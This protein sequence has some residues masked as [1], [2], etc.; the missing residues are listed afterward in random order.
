MD[1][2]RSVSPEQVLLFV[3]LAYIGIFGLLSRTR[4]ESLSLQFAIEGLVITGL[5]VVATRLGY[6]VNPIL[7]FFIL[8]TVTMRARWLA[9]LGN[10]LVAR[11]RYRDGLIAFNVALSLWPDAL[12]RR[13]VEINKAV[14]FLRLGYLERA[15]AMLEKVLQSAERD[16]LSPKHVAAVHYNLGIIARAEGDE[17]RARAHFEE[18]VNVAPY[19]IYGYGARQALAGKPLATRTVSDEADAEGGKPPEELL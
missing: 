17:S 5:A 11:R 2:W 4:H 18:A 16:G 9:D 7:F 13:I 6:S 12:S 19:T 1:W 10:L 14:A 3:G 15:R 8:Y